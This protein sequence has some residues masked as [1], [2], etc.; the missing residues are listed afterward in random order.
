MKYKYLIFIPAR[1]GSKTLKNKNVKK[2]GKKT[3]LEIQAELSV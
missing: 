3:L 2:I 1:E